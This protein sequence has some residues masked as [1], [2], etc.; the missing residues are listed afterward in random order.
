MAS[1]LRR[2][3]MDTSLTHVYSRWGDQGD[4][5][6]LM[7]Y[8][9][10]DKKWPDRP[11]MNFTMK[12]EERPILH[13]TDAIKLKVVNTAVNEL[14]GF[15]QRDQN[16][17]Y[18]TKTTG[19]S[20]VSLSE[21]LL[22]DSV[23]I[24]TTYKK[25]LQEQNIHTPPHILFVNKED[26]GRVASIQQRA[27]RSGSLH[28]K[29]YESGM[30]NKQLKKV[31]VYA[32]FEKP[33]K[34]LI[35]KMMLPLV[36][37]IVIILTITGLLL[38]FYHTI[39][40]QKKLSV[41]KNDFIDNMTHELKTPIATIS[42]AAEAMQ[43]FGINND[44]V[45]TEKYLS[46]IRGQAVQLNNIVN[47]VLDISTLEKQELSLKKIN[48]SIIRLLQE[49]KENQQFLYPNTKLEIEVP[50]MEHSIYGD[51]FHLKNVFFNLVDNAIKYNDKEIPMV[52]IS[53]E[54]KE[55]ELI[56]RVRDNGPGVNKEELPHLFDK[57]YRVPQGNI[58]RVK[59]FGLGLFY[60][61]KI[62]DM[63]KGNITIESVVGKETT[64]T[65]ELPGLL[66]G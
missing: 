10:Q 47:K 24:Q 25:L 35:G 34:W 43:R 57:F 48:F 66:P 40:R 32:I 55:Q 20:A 14:R 37:S 6:G 26:T 33:W 58:Q 46:A 38:H 61:K 44:P 23:Q 19:D 1:S 53:A 29:L 54:Q 52:R 8:Y 2:W 31:L 18:Y 39:N 36:L 16:I 27:V 7:V 13:D 21:K 3:L 59:G 50:D 64:V 12:N 49:I 9:I 5:K 30:Y 56:V 11:P 60:V 4:L 51:P 45:K 63:H 22:I 41:L 42:A 62:I 17:F 65:I 28:T 15:Y